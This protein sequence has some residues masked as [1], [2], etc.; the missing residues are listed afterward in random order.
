ME[1]E[2]RDQESMQNTPLYLSST[3][4]MIKM[5]KEEGLL[6]HEKMRK[7]Q[8]KVHLFYAVVKHPPPS[9]LLSRPD[10]VLDQTHT[11][12]LGKN[13]EQIMREYKRH[14]IL[15]WSEGRITWRIIWR[16]WPNQSKMKNQEMMMA[17]R[18]VANKI[19]ILGHDDVGA[20]LLFHVSWLCFCRRNCTLI[21]SHSESSGLIHGRVSSYIDSC[22]FYL[23][24]VIYSRHQSHPSSS[25]RSSSSQE[26]PCNL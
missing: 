19:D 1:I 15:R 3:I 26:G 14:T 7:K 2:S 25:S 10:L 4:M 16:I 13:E 17:S 20:L 6:F 9:S 24:M 11:K 22:P 21:T 5:M 12:Y 23:P 18:K 8:E